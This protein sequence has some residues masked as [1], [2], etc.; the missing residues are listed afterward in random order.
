MVIRQERTVKS[1]GESSGQQRAISPLNR[2]TPLV[3][4]AVLYYA[5]QNLP[6][7][8]PCSGYNLGQL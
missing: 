5:A 3:E 7:L 2:Q 6:W 8:L 1:N 4:M